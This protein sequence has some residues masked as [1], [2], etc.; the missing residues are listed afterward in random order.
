MNVIAYTYPLLDVCIVTLAPDEEYTFAQKSASASWGFF[1]LGGGTT[2]LEGAIIGRTFTSFWEWCP[3]NISLGWAN[4]YIGHADMLLKAMPEGAKWLC[5]SSNGN[6]AIKV[7]HQKVEGSFTLPAEM[8]F[9][10]ATGSVLADGKTAVQAN[11]FKP[12]LYD[13]DIV[14]TA[15]L[16]IVS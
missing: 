16:L 11:Y 8:G 9:V 15:D 6:G 2:M 4:D 3:N 7:Q 5:L 1:G 14:G 10:V 12:R 13:V